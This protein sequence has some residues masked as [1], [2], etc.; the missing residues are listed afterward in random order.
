M[1]DEMLTIEI[2]DISSLVLSRCSKCGLLVTPVYNTHLHIYLIGHDCPVTRIN[3][4]YVDRE[5]YK[6][7]QYWNTVQGT[8]NINKLRVGEVKTPSYRRTMNNLIKKGLSK[9]N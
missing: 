8:A 6:L 5:F 7:V 3:T 1:I 2:S 4:T 9:K